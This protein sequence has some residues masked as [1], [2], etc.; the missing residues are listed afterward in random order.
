VFI[1]YNGF[2]NDAI[3]SWPKGPLPVGVALSCLQS[4]TPYSIVAKRGLNDS[5]RVGEIN[6][7]LTWELVRCSF[8]PTPIVSP[9]L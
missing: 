1:F 9:F 5:W 7:A 2:R 6:F 3:F 4:L 8:T